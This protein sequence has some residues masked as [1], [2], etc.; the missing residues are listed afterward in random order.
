[1]ASFHE[2][3]SFV[4]LQLTVPAETLPAR[5]VALAEEQMSGAVSEGTLTSRVDALCAMLGGQAM[6]AD[7]HAAAA[8]TATTAATPAPSPAPNELTSESVNA[9]ERPDATMRAVAPGSPGRGCPH[10]FSELFLSALI[11]SASP[12]SLTETRRPL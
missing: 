9:G 3:L 8:A 7:G 4:K 12:G 10:S 2:K 6:I 5:A 11:L 1:M